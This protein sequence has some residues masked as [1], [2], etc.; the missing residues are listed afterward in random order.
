[1]L[2]GDADAGRELVQHPLVQK[3]SFTGGLVTAQKILTAC[4]ESVKPVCLELGGKSANIIFEDA[5]LD[6]S[7]GH[8]TLMSVGVLSGQG[9]AFPTRMLVQESVYDDVVE[10]VASAAKSIAVG[11]PWD[12][13]TLAGP[14]ISQKALERILA[15]IERAKYDGA[16]LVTGGAR[17]EGDLSSGYYIEPTV[18]ADVDPYSELAQNEVFGPVL[19]ITPFSTEDDAIRIANATRFGLSGYVQTKDLRRALRLAEELVTGE[20]LINGAANL[21]VQRPFGGLGLSGFGKEGGRLGIEEFLRV[22]G[23]GIGGLR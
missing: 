20:V 4:A 12:P 18:L 23:V 9:C 8:G 16:R 14:V 7:C 5:D 13:A 17:L 15:M 21:R 19:A 2:P 11:D 1:M 6:T 22:K 3:I 10:R